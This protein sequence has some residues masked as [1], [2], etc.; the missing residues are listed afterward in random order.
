MHLTKIPVGVQPV[1][2]SELWPVYKCIP[3]FGACDESLSGIVIW[4]HSHDPCLRKAIGFNR[5]TVACR[6]RQP[7]GMAQCSIVVDY[8]LPTSSDNQEALV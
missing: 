2:P 5:S 1:S 7:Q 6:Y 4:H 8:F 3:N